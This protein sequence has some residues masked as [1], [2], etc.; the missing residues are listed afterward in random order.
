MDVACRLVTEV[1][2][3]G[4]SVSLPRL[5]PQ[6]AKLNLAEKLEAVRVD[7]ESR[8]GNGNQRERKEE[9]DYLTLSLSPPAAAAAATGS[10]L[11]SLP[12]YPLPFTTRMG[13]SALGE[14]IRHAVISGL[15][16][17]N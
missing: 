9:K 10:P 12:S 16:R 11:L 6:E 5:L 2:C 3:F 1:F 15:A 14:A 17:V 4:V 7:W 13:L 8:E